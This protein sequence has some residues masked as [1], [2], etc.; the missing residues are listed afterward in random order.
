MERQE[1]DEAID[2]R[3]TT[4]VL[5]KWY[6]YV[7]SL[8]VL[9]YGG[10]NIILGVLDRDYTQTPK[11]L[12]FLIIGVILMSVCVAFRDRKPWGWYG[13]V[14]V[15]GLI[16]ILC[17]IGYREPLNLVCLASSLGCLFLLFTPQI[18]AETF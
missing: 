13:L 17:L 10:V 3:P 8:S 2:R 18:K 5:V 14:G 6:G 9:L 12:V 16:V 1:V 4:F 15:N 7:I 11:S